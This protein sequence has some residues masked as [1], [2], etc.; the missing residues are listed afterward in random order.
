MPTNDNWAKV[1]QRRNFAGELVG[2]GAARQAFQAWRNCAERA[3]PDQRGWGDWA[4]WL[5]KDS[6]SKGPLYAP[7]ASGPFG[8]A[9]L[10]DLVEWIA[11][12]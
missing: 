5:S 1:T 4:G 9:R 10:P 6:L 12:K 3:G 2:T 11:R 7:A 8:V